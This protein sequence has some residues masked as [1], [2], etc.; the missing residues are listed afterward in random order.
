MIGIKYSAK[1]IRGESSRKQRVV[2]PVVLV[3]SLIEDNRAVVVFI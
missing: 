3:L 2:L 1:I